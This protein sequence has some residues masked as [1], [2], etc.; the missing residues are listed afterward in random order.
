VTSPNIAPVIRK[1]RAATSAKIQLCLGNGAGLLLA[2]FL[3]LVIRNSWVWL[4][5]HHLPSHPRWQ[6]VDPPWTLARFDALPRT[7][8]SFFELG[9]VLGSHL[10]RTI[11]ITNGELHFWVLARRDVYLNAEF[12]EGS[13][14]LSLP[15]QL[16]G[17]APESLK[18]EWVFNISGHHPDRFVVFAGKKRYH[19][20]GSVVE[21]AIQTNR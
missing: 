4:S 15:A 1:I 20:Q 9:L 5:F 11:T 8:S 16:E 7:W 18:Y 2:V 13:T 14:E 6:F 21:Y 12:Y 10:N 19:Y 3:A 17:R